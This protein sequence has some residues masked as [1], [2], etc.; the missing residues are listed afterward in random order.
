M[1]QLE[2]AAPDKCEMCD[3]ALPT[4]ADRH[5]HMGETKHCRCFECGKYMPPGQAYVHWSILHDDIQWNDHG[6]A[7]V[8][9]EMLRE[10]M[11]WARE[12]HEKRI[13]DGASGHDGTGTSEEGPS[14]VG[15]GRKEFDDPKE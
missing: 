1:Q 3:H 5:K 8:D 2:G 15:D 9:T 6:V 4:L 13:R 11:P 14:A 12:A 7:S 10:A